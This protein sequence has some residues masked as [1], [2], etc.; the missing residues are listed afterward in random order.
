MIA[1]DCNYGI[2]SP[3]VKLSNRTKTNILYCD[4]QD[5]R[6]PQVSVLSCLYNVAAESNDHEGSG[7]QYSG[8]RDF[9]KTI[10]TA[11]S[12]YSILPT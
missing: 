7:P 2:P 12:P 6:G 5:L 10:A 3:I 9:S 4:H 8:A 1:Y 11:P